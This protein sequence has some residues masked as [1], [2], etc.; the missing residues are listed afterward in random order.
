M[1]SEEEVR[2][3]PVYRRRTQQSDARSAA[4]NR[5][6]TPGLSADGS[7]CGH[8][9][10]HWMLLLLAQLVDFRHGRPGILNF[11]VDPGT[12]TQMEKSVDA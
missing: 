3:D 12:P 6:Y 5:P 7:D 1:H 9:Y 2:Q 11:N 8:V 4:G 10:K